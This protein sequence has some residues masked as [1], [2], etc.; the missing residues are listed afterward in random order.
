MCIQK[1]RINSAIAVNDEVF[2]NDENTVLNE[3]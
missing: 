3:I 2:K 1:Q